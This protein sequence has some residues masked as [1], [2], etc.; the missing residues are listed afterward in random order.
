M[1]RCTLAVL[2]PFLVLL[3]LAAGPAAAQ[4]DEYEMRYGRTIEVSIDDLIQFP[5]SYEGKAVRTKGT[6]ELLPTAGNVTHTLRGLFGGRVFIVPLPEME[7]EFEVQARRWL[8]RDVEVTGVVSIGRDPSSGSQGTVIGIW[9]FLGPPDEKPGARPSAETATLEEL[10]TRPGKRDGKMVRVAGQFRGE[11]LFGDLPSA[12]RRRSSDWVLKEDVYA[13]WVTGKKPRGPGWTLDASL[14]RDTGKWLQVMGRVA[15]ERGV[16]YIEA[17]DV[18]LGKPSAPVEQAQAPAPPPPR[19]KKPPVVVFSL[20]VDGER[21]VP[22]NST[23]QIQFSKDM[24]EQSLKGRVVLRY[25]GRPQPGDRELDSVKM[26]YDEGRRAL[27]IDPGDLLR[28]GRT[29]EILLLSGIVDIDGL[30]LETRPGYSA[31]GAVDVLRFQIAGGLGA[32]PS[33]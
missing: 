19:P 21:D 30:A 23:F 33:S 29:V 32:G 9:A 20:P 28:P 22:P 16:V 14:K 31:G 7:G 24:D 3:A 5:E 25:A 13:V 10:V 4:V 27:V 2:S 1:G 17:V 12:S 8:G 11:N 26:T 15:T 18:T 6:L